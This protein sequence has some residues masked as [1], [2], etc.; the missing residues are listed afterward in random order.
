MADAK[1]SALTADTSPTSD[2][3]T[4][5]VNDPGGTP[6]NRKVTLGDLVTKAHGLSDSTVVG[7]ASGVLTSGTDVSVVDGGTGA[8]TA[9]G[10]R[11][12]L[13]LVI[14][15]DVAPVNSPSLITPSIGEANGTGLTLSSNSAGASTPVLR[16]TKIGVGDELTPSITA[17]FKN[18][19]DVVAGA[20]DYE[21]EVHLRLQAGTTT[22]HRKYL[23]FADYTGT[24]VW[25]TGSNASNV[26]I[27][28]DAVSLAHRLWME[29]SGTGNGYTYLSSAGTGR[30]VLNGHSDDATGTGG[31]YIAT[32]GATP[33]TMAIFAS[34]GTMALGVG[35][36]PN[37]RYAIT[38]NTDNALTT[39]GS[40]GA[41][42]INPNYAASG[43]STAAYTALNIAPTCDSAN[44]PG[45]FAGEFLVANYNAVG[46]TLAT[47]YGLYSVA[48]NSNTSTVTNA[49]GV[50]SG[51]EN[52]N[53]G[54]TITNG[55][56]FYVPILSNSG[57]V[58][59]FYGLRVLDSTAATLT[60][61]VRLGM[62]VG[63]GKWNIYADGTA[64]NTI[65]GKT[66]HGSTS[67]PTALLH[68]DAGT[69]SA[70]TAPLKFTSGSLLT[71]PEAGAIEFLTD[72]YYATITT[73]SSRKT[74]AFLE[75]PIFPTNITVG[76]AGSSTG[77]ILLK[78]TTSGTVTLTVPSVAGS[79]TYVLPSAVGSAGSFL[80][81][82]AGDGILSWATPSGSA[83]P[84]TTK[85]DVYTFSTVD[86]RLGVGT[87][88]QVLTA[89]SAETTGLKW[90][91]PAGGGD[92]LTSSPLSQFAATTS[93]QLA[94]VMSDETGSGALVFAV[95]PTLVTPILGTPT[96]GTLTNCTGLPVNGI[97]DDTTSA[98][99]VGSLE[100]G[101]ASD[102]TFTRVSAGV[103]AIEGSN[104]LTAASGAN[105]FKRQMEFIIGDGTDV[106]T[107]GEKKT[108]RVQI[109]VAGTITGW[110][111]LSLD[112]TS[113]SVTLDIWKDTYANY[114]PTVAD[115]ITA[116]AKPSI[117]TATKNTSTTLTGW[118]TSITAGDI[119]SVNVDSVAS[120]KAIKLIVNYTVT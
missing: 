34:D 104:I 115:T 89:D 105:L 5:T 111:I 6:A 25:L 13:G 39:S 43:A 53:A 4:V 33:S 2:D 93:A 10:A 56:G 22:N 42:L 46:T 58:T 79:P 1:I 41:F 27:L 48:R 62:L 54:G 86:A 120:L 109:P 73:G 67:V 66:R 37:S 76:S 118:T 38:L 15:T 49:Y 16:V 80:K 47:Q 14:G 108:A 81:D 96:S 51:I 114:P 57:T 112:D 100:L 31:V 103:A 9:S 78:G 18:T 113:G 99:G 90:S 28:Y 61:G 88:G 63:T 110:T 3:L 12:N 60:V 20:E 7:V 107:T 70:S 26:W 68:L 74:F 75:S 85:G 87:N 106:I 35:T 30:L 65:V 45:L 32:G 94:G 21:N 52:T 95:T 102:T 101:H 97:V 44:P 98:L 40:T 82:S 119:L 84:L 72:S 55:Y 64:N 50:L 19:S 8:S 11:T 24:D 69:A 116:A 23:N 83:S 77:S 117:T 29:N 92:A 91:N 17:L 71:S 59:N 36:T